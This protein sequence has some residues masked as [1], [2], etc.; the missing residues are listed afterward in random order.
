MYVDAYDVHEE[1]YV[2]YIVSPGATPLSLIMMVIMMV[3][4]MME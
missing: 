1:M 2:D 3:I 4:M